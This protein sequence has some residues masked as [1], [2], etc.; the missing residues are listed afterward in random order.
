MSN[1]KLPGDCRFILIDPL[2]CLE[3]EFADQIA[4][5]VVLASSFHPDSSDNVH[6]HLAHPSKHMLDS[7]PDATAQGVRCFL[8]LCQGMPMPAFE[9]D[10][11]FAVTIS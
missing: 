1:P 3:L 8:L 9:H 5:R 11:I 4:E 10:E 6:A 2:W 7:H